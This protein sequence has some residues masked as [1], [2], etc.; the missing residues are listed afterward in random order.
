MLHVSTL[1]HIKCIMYDTNYPN[2][3]NMDAQVKGKLAKVMKN[4][5][6]MEPFQ[7]YILSKWVSKIHM[8]LVGY[9]NLPYVGQNT[10]VMIESQHSNL[11]ATLKAS[12]GRA[13]GCHIYCTIHK[14]TSDVLSL[15]LAPIDVVLKARQI[16]DTCVMLSTQEGGVAIFK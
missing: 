2:D 15:L 1:K 11:K 10:N 6:S 8:W 5:S 13:H 3:E 4:M 16:L 7:I 12:K 14:L 9:Q